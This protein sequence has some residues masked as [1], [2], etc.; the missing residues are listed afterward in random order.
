MSATPP[1]TPAGPE[2][3]GAIGAYASTKQEILLMLKRQ[4]QCDMQEV[5]KH[6]G[7]SR[8]AVHKHAKDL[9]ARGLIERVPVRSGPGRPRLAMRLA[10]KAS[11]LFPKAYAEVSCSALAFIEEK[12]G[13]KG[14]EEALRRRQ[15]TVL[16]GYKDRVQADSLAGR[17]K[18]LTELRDEEGYMAE[19]RGGKQ[20]AFEIIEYNCPIREIAERYWEAC[21]VENEMFRRVLKADVETTHRVVAGAHA[22]QFLIKPRKG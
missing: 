11:N 19:S 14:V 7:I 22:C 13:R 18:Q 17:V 3:T 1:P 4:G 10:P 15:T 21:T 8:M 2:M 9:E 12:M 5:A 16:P 6:L 20:G